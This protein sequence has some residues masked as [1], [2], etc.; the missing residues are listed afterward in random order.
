MSQYAMYV[1]CAGWTEA[2]GPQYMA[3]SVCP[4]SATLSSSVGT[5]R[6]VLAI[7]EGTIVCC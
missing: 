1:L 5:E 3:V 4:L 6:C 2:S 7:C